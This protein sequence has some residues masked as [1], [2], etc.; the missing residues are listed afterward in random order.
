MTTAEATVIANRF[1]NQLNA[2]WQPEPTY[3]W[4]V[5]EMT[6][7]TE[8]YYF[9]WKFVDLEGEEFTGPTIAGPPGFTVSKYDGY[10][11]IVSYMEW[12]ELHREEK[13]MDDLLAMTMNLKENNV[14]LDLFKSTYK[15]NTKQL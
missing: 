15:L 12:S 6:E 13:R 7:F 1:I 10:A 5:G 8:C 3:K 2:S 11:R 9:A 14:G 4:G